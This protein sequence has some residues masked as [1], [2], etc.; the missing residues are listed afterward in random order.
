MSVDILRN[1]DPEWVWSAVQHISK[2]IP[3]DDRNLIKKGWDQ[4][5]MDRI[6]E[7]GFLSRAREARADWQESQKK[8]KEK[9]RVEAL[10][11]YLLVH[12]SLEGFDMDKDYT[13]HYRQQDVFRGLEEAVKTLDGIPGVVPALVPGIQGYKSPGSL[14]KTWD[15]AESLKFIL[16]DSIFLLYPVLRPLVTLGVSPVSSKNFSFFKKIFFEEHPPGLPRGK[17][18]GG[19]KRDLLASPEL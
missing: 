5:Y 3:D 1:K 4:M 6:R 2:Q 8:A 9:A 18:D 7:E 13:E 12:D 11:D 15:K 14:G 19:C 17:G 10:K 16:I